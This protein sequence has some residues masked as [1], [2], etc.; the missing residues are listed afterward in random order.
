MPLLCTLMVRSCSALP[1]FGAL[2]QWCRKPTKGLAISAILRAPL[3][4]ASPATRCVHEADRQGFPRNHHQE[5]TGA[6][7]LHS[8]ADE[9][10]P[11]RAQG[12]GPCAPGRGCVGQH[13]GGDFRRRGQGAARDDRAVALHARHCAFSR[14]PRIPAGR[15]GRHRRKMP[16][17]LCRAPA[18]AHLRRALQACRQA[19]VQLD[20]RRAPRR[21]PAAPALRRRRH[22]AEGAGSRSAHGDP[23]PAPVRRASAA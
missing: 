22:L 17:A 14:G 7:G 4:Q 9:K 11:R 15:P 8:S 3:F 20:G 18:G 21:Q 2:R 13:R 16:G 1:P 10:H 12:P 19:S 23:R 6:Q 5:P